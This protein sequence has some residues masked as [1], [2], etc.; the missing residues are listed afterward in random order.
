[1]T[2]IILIILFALILV[3]ISAGI[4]MFNLAI[5]VITAKKYIT[6]DFNIFNIKK[7]NEEIE[8]SIKWLRKN[9]KVRC[10]KSSDNL[11]LCGYEIKNEKLSDVWIIAVHGYMGEGLDMVPYAQKFVDMGYNALIIDQRAH[12][13]SEGKYRG[14]GYLECKDLKNWI[15]LVTNENKNSK[16]I[17]YG[18]S[19]GATTVMMETGEKL[20]DNVRVCIEDCG[21]TSI[22]EEFKTIYKKSFRL[23]S[24]PVLNI[25]S[26]ASRI[27]AGYFFKQASAL[28]AVKKSKIPTI[29]IHGED[30]RLVPCKMA[31]KLY[32]VAK[33]KKEKLIIKK[34]G[35]TESCTVDTEMYWKKIKAFIKCY[36]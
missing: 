31:E 18:V 12:G 28:K 26:I 15:E 6:E 9:A 2:I 27:K 1:M 35:H 29:F 8:E 5:N 22:W 25:A 3:C 23:P 11:R 7:T 4:Y 17:L 19:M 32:K 10:I 20:P 13:C 16:I 36:I 14:M 30:D 34:A 21:Y 24:F 33:C